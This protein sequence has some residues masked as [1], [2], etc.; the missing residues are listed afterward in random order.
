M[1]TWYHKIHEHCRY[2]VVMIRITAGEVSA[3]PSTSQ[4]VYVSSPWLVHALCQVEWLTEYSGSC[5]CITN[6]LYT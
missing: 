6:Q 3:C 5:E 4:G 2:S 1:I